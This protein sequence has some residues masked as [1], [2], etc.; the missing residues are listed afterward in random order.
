MLFTNLDE[1]LDKMTDLIN[2]DPFKS[3]VYFKYFHEKNNMV[4]KVTND[5]KSIMMKID[6]K[7]DLKKLEA[8]LHEAT[9]LLSNHKDSMKMEKM[10]GRR[11]RQ[12]KRA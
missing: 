3:R 2:R 11:R 9:K 4:I 1:F 6:E 5:K 12:D 10:G 8:I 7:A